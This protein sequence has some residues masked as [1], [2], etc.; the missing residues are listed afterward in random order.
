[1]HAPKPPRKTVKAA[2]GAT[3]WAFAALIGANGALAVGPW[4]VRVADTGP[5]ASGFWRLALAAPLLAILAMRGGWRPVGLGRKLWIVLAISGLCF[6]AD[7][8]C[9]NLGILRTTLANSTLFGNSAI[10]FFPIY[11][12]FVARAWPT[13]SQGLALL[14]ALAGAVLLMGR[15]Y[16][17]DPRHL[18]GD[19]LCLVAGMLYTIYFVCMA[20]A[21]DTMSPFPALALSTIASIVPILVFAIALG[22]R[23]MPHNWW[24]L[25][26]IALVSQVIGQSLMIYA[27]GRFSPLVVGIALLTQP[28]IAATIGWLAYGERL[29]LP[30]LVG[31][32]L[33]AIA[34]VLVR[35][36]P[37]E[38]DQLAAE[39]EATR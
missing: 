16:Q 26:G 32:V 21:R 35:E 8:A 36:G 12:F 2:S 38:L 11:G 39:P 17:L 30:D 5:V 33:V 14:L 19:M 29:G 7:L 27:L 24:P 1:M 23:V 18:F 20:R 22:E 13:R 37:K 4:F 10:L 31:G 25:L 9:W 6:A 3:P 34:L 15:S 28:V